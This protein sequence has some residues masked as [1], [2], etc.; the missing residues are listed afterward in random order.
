MAVS[1]VG[2]FGDGELELI[3]KLA[4]NLAYGIGRIRD[5]KNLA[6]NESRLR[7]SRARLRLSSF[8]MRQVRR[9]AA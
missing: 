9:S 3:G 1:S 4:D 6:L 7:A 5:A 8:S 2:M